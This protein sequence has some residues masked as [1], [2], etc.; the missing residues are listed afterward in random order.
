M[1]KVWKISCACCY[2]WIKYKIVGHG[3]LWYS[4]LECI[5]DERRIEDCKHQQL[6]Y[7]F[8]YYKTMN[9]EEIPTGDPECTHGEEA[10]VV[11]HTPDM[12]LK[13]KV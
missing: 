7:P 6:A 8:D 13:E 9:E 3:P 10:G 12:R 2:Y 4:K 5:G 1:G 11:C